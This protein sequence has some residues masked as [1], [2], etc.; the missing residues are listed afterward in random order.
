MRERIQ[1]LELCLIEDAHP[2]YVAVQK[3][4]RFALAAQELLAR[5]PLSDG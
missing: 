4:R 2:G 3:S 5:H 1:G